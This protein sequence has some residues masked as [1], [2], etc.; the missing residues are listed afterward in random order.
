MQFI[1]SQLTHDKSKPRNALHHNTSAMMLSSTSNTSKRLPSSVCYDTVKDVLGPEAEVI[2]IPEFLERY[3]PSLGNVSFDK[4]DPV[5]RLVC[6]TLLSPREGCKVTGKVRVARNQSLF[7][8]VDGVVLQLVKERESQVPKKVRDARNLLSQGFGIGSDLMENVKS[9]NLPIE[10]I[11]KGLVNH[12]V[13]YCKTSPIMKWL[14]GRFGDDVVRH[15]LLHCAIFVPVDT[16]DGKGNYLQIAG[17]LL[18]PKVYS[19]QHSG[20]NQKRK[21]RMRRGLEV[22]V[23]LQPQATLSRKGLFYSTSFVPK[24]GFPQKGHVFND[25]R[26]DPEI[27]VKEWVGALPLSGVQLQL[28]VEIASQMYRRHKNCDYSRLLNRYCPLPEGRSSM[29]LQEAATASTDVDKVLSFLR[30]CLRRLIPPQFLGTSENLDFLLDKQVETFVR[31]RRR[32][33]FSNKN[34]IHGIRLAK[35]E[36]LCRSRGGRQSTADHC[37]AELLLVQILRWLFGGLIVPLLSSNFYV[38]E[39]EFSGQKVLFYRRPVWSVF[40]RLSMNKLLDQQYTEISAQEASRRLSVQRMGFSRLRLLPKATGVRPIALLC[41]RA[42]ILTS[43][44]EP[45]KSAIR[46]ASDDDECELALGGLTKKLKSSHGPVNGWFRG[47][48]KISQETL[49]STNQILNSAFSVLTYEQQRDGELF[50]AGL[51]GLFYLY[52][53]YRRF[54]EHLK[55]NQRGSPLYCCSVDIRSCYDNIDQKHLSGVIESILSEDDYLIQR[56]D[57]FHPFESMSRVLKQQR[58]RVGPPESFRA[59]YSIV[60]GLGGDFRRSVF[61]DCVS[62]S[63]I[64]RKLLL[65]QLKEHLTSHLVTVSDRKGDRYLLQSTG[66]PQGSVLSTLLCNF[67]YGSVERRL[68]P[69]KLVDSHSLLREEPAGDLL[70]RMVDDFMLW[71]TDLEVLRDFLVVMDRGDRDLGVQINK[72]KTKVSTS[73]SFQGKDGMMTLLSPCQEAVSGFFPWCGMLFDL[74]NGHVRVDYSRF[75]DGQSGNSLTVERSRNEG[76]KFAVAMKAF[77][78][79]RCVPLLFDMAIND[80]HNQMVNFFQLLLLGGVRMCEY[81]RSSEMMPTLTSNVG[82]IMAC[83]ESTIV[84]AFN[85]IKERLGREGQHTDCRASFD[86]AAARWL[87]W[88]AFGDVVRR[89]PD[90]RC[91]VAPID[92]K[93]SFVWRDRDAARSAACEALASLEIDRLVGPGGPR[94]TRG[95]LR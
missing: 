65:D 95:S 84:Y 42:H 30:A 62:T 4:S 59:L 12:N 72:D 2:T 74:R 51:N 40:R 27:L 93:R 11:N 13:D 80:V 63:T 38:T 55:N 25:K 32:E 69:R 82:F 70:V 28:A 21:G 52:P 8:L 15:L 43:G 85:L 29:D 58:K 1:P 22:P 88:K 17:L 23:H 94:L 3:F 53:R 24:I 33:H 67:Y 44:M 57:I 41:K 7:S 47:H 78:R 34:L 75:Y 9:R 89:R 91:L 31:L 48:R 66:I 73:V 49:L 18:Q 37:V 83:I 5:Q 19:N 14:H 56:Y 36:W 6:H 86:Q 68:L 39:S 10:I 81:L 77:V 64:Q 20:V 35:I 90:F 54:V 26:S 50:G 61:S 60:D 45:K 92:Q 76:E 87:G 71:T 16:D 46:G 79:P